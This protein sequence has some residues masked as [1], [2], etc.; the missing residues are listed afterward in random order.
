MNKTNSAPNA[1]A[2]WLRRLSGRAN[3]HSLALEP[4]PPVSWPTES[5]PV[6]TPEDQGIDSAKLVEMVAY[7]EAQ[8]AKKEQI[9][10]DSITMARN[11][12]I[13]AD[14][15]LNPMFP[16]NTKHVIHSCTKSIMSI[17]IG[18][19]I[20]EEYL[21]G[22]DVPVLEIFPDKKCANRDGRLQALTL[23]DLLTMQTGLRSRDSYLYEWEG[24]FAMQ[25]ADD[26][27]EFTLNLPFDVE[28]GTRFDYSNVSSLLLSAIIA[29]T[30]G[31]DT[32]S[33]ARRYLFQPLGI[34][35]V[36]WAQSPQ[37]IYIG[38]ARMW[39]KPRDMAKIGLLYLHKGRWDGRQI[40][41]ARWVE[42]STSP[43]A[44]P[45]RYR[46]VPDRNGERDLQKTIE[47]WIATRVIRP[48]ADGYGYQ[49]WLDKS[50]SYSALGVGGQYI[51]VV[52]GGNLVVVFTSKLSGVDSFL[53][54]KLLEK[55]ILPAI[56]S[57]QALPANRPAQAALAQLSEPPDP[58]LDATAVPALPAIAHEISGK[59]YLLDANPWHHDD[60]CLVFDRIAEFA[61]F[62]YSTRQGEVVI[63][64]V[65]LDN[66]PRT[67]ETGDDIYAAAGAWT[68]PD[69][70][71]IEYEQVGYS[72]RGKWTLTFAGDEIVVEE[73]SVTGTYTYRGRSA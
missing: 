5:W 60:F 36:R 28:P 35:D 22:V 37:G 1:L 62:G 26:W 52:P 32:L 17:L 10:I 56:L 72:N 73:G 18:I 63:Y 48:F 20:A 58:A 45:K 46:P 65:G 49:W 23:K 11:G 6:S 34:D 8:R 29:R 41:P 27:V 16:R 42:E 14:I 25:A 30:T 66:V 67:T 54:A 31:M 44:F 57:D 7:Y 19:A 2:T 9:Q 69:T 55:Y 13:V 4:R 3:S 70:F 40:V 51:T 64:Q 68:A 21:D 24:L 33:F 12:I 47:N 43:H 50:G 38:W 59:R 39:L 15:Y 61:E 71:T 53:P